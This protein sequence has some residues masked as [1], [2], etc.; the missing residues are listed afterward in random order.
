MK[1]FSIEILRN[2]DYFIS[3]LPDSKIGNKFRELYF[4]R[5]LKLKSRF[6]VLSFGVKFNHTHL[7]E[8]GTSVSIG[9]RVT[10]DAGASSGIFI[11]NNV[12]I[13]SGVYIRSGNHN[14]SNT[15]VE[16]SEQGYSSKSLEYNGNTYSIVIEDSVWIGA[17][18]ILLSGSHIGKGAILSAGSVISGK[19]T[20]YS[21]VVGN[22]GRVVG[23]R[24]IIK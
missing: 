11:G 17:N 1:L 9:P 3:Y 13:A 7:I 19:V 16:I 8:F 20:D 14:F 6:K 12:L 4:K 22:P 18:A 21:I 10:I 23:N 24:L 5:R 15:N 2:F